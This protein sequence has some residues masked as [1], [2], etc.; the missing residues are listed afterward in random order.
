MRCL[1][2]GRKERMVILRRCQWVSVKPWAGRYYG[3]KLRRYI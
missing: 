3:S 2:P 1:E